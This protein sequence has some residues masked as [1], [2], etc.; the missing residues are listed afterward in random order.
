MVEFVDEN[1]E[2]PDICFGAIDV[3]NETL[4][5]H[6][7]RASDGD[8]PEGMLSLDSESEIPQF[9]GVPLDED[10]GHFDIPVYDS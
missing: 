5:T 8:V 10:I 1:S 9:E 6:V 2:G 3:M 7:E 4:R